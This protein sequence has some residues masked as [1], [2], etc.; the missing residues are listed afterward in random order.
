MGCL[1]SIIRAGMGLV[2]GAVIFV[3]FALSLLLSNFSDK[4]LS[5]D[6]YKNT[7]A[8]EDTYNRIYD[9]VL[10]DDEL[11]EKTA[12]F[13]GDIKVVNHQEIV[14][15]LR[16]IIPLA[17]IQQEV[18]ASIDRTVD[19]I[20]EDV[21]FLEAYVDLTEPLE[22]VKP[23]MFAYLDQKIDQLE[24]IDPGTISCSLDGLTDPRLG[25]LADDYLTEFTSMADGEVPV[26]VP[27]LNVLTPLC[28]QLLFTGFY[29]QLLSST[30]LPA[31]VNRSLRDQRERLR[32]PFE[33]GDTLGVLKVAS[34]LLTEP[35]MDEAIV[36]VRQDL[37]DGD[38]FD[39]IYQLGEWDDSTSEAQIRSDIAD[40]RDW[41][42][43]AR[44]FGD[45]ATLIMVFG[46]A[47]VMGLVFFPSLSSMLRWPGLILFI[48][49]LFF[50]VV[51]KIAESKV[52][53][54]LTDVV[55][56]GADKVSDVPPSVA[57]LGG[58]ILISFG[59]Q[60]TDGFT[61]P[62]M[63]LLILGLLLFGGSFF[64]AIFGR[65]IPFVK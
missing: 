43:K 6:F 24:V 20:N 3:G 47:V 37:K 54:R 38:R 33:S 13:L 40:G 61:G 62:S 11:K 27:S 51:G 46:G 57:D 39:L 21:E 59:S 10:V 2:L 19:Y 42:S 5:A 30:D 45:V 28:R 52:P 8:A 26:G 15:L 44:N 32:A 29:D 65:F 60:M 1:F 12:E 7:I 31:E 25:N 18:E 14:D 63:T 55:E 41:I 50:F 9:E 48:T 36:Q 23:V 35:L 56:T 4:L 16:E 17:Y 49:G 34:R 53:D 22:N 58:D 64:A